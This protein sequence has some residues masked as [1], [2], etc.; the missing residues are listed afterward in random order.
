MARARGPTLEGV[1]RR[2]AL[3]ALCTTLAVPVAAAAADTGGVSYEAGGASYAPGGSGPAG[4]AA[5]GAALVTP[6]VARRFVLSP[7]RVRAD[8][9]PVVVVRVQQPD[10][11]RVGARLTLQDRR[12]R[13]LRVDLGRIRTGRT[14]RLR[15]PS[16][17]R[18]AVGRYRV[19]LHVT[20][21]GAPLARSARARGETRLTVVA[22]PKPKPKPVVVRPVKPVTP[23]T[24]AAPTTP[25]ASVTAGVF[26]VAGPHSYGDGI[27][28]AR[29][30]HTHQ[31]V[32][33]VAAEGTPVVAPTAGTIAFVDYQRK[34]AGWYV[35]QNADDGRAFFFAHCRTN[36][37]VV[38]PGQRVAP[39]DRLCGVGHT[40]DAAGPHLHFEI[41]VG[42]WRVDKHSHFVDPLA[43]LRSWDR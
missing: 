10:V 21:A 35:V 4:G 37:I 23:V 3:T 14:L 41:W 6:P 1:L 17:R 7:A 30:G 43:Q 26:P 31:G 29:D 11:S 32:D 33:I 34:G 22:P 28:A 5:Y 24:P 39:G 36:T 18:L 40:G 9:R 27:G 15:W 42:G 25:S 2:I 20:G 12:G 16:G 19:L 8:R 38:Q 13:V